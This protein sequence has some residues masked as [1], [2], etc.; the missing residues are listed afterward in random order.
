MKNK[1]ANKYIAA[2]MATAMLSV[3][4]VDAF[5]NDS[6][7]DKQKTFDINPVKALDSKSNGESSKA[8]TSNHVITLITG[9]VVT[10]TGVEGG[11]SVISVEY[12]DQVDGGAQFLTLGKD[13]Y[14]VPNQAMPYLASGLLDEELFNITALIADGYDDGEQS[15]LPVIVQYAPTKARFEAAL[16]AALA[17]S[18]RTN[19][20]ESIGGVAVSADKEQVTSFWDDIT[21][22]VAAA[23]SQKAGVQLNGVIEKIWLDGR[24]EANLAQSVPMI[25]APTAWDAG[26]DGAGVKIAVLDS[27]IDTEHPDVAGQID[28]AV[29]FVPGEDALDY[30][31]HGTHVA[32]T[33]LGT[34]AASEGRNKG[35][36]PGA[37]LLTGKVLASNGFGQDSWVIEGMEW[38]AENAKVVNMSLGDPTPSDGTDPMSQAVN[39]L[40]KETGALFVIAS[41]NAGTEGIGSPGAADAAL[42]VG[43]VDKSDNLAATSTRGPRYMESGLKPDLVAPGTDITAARSHLAKQGM[44]SY[45]TLSGTSM[46]APHVAGAAAILSQRYPEWTGEQLKN[47][48]MSSTKKL[49]HI[50][51]YEGGSGRLDVAAATSNTIFA[52]GSLDFGHYTWPHDGDDSVE[53]T[54]T[55]TN[56]SDSPVTLELSTTFKD[57]NGSEAPDGL[58][59]LSS[60]EVTVPA[61]GSADVFV[62]VDPESGVAGNRYQGQLSAIVDG[63]TVAHTAMVMGKEEEKYALTINATDR[64]GSPAQTLISIVG[65]NKEPEFLAVV[66]TKELRLPPGVYSVMSLMD[67]DMDTDHAGVALLGNPEIKLDGPQTL[68]LDARNA[69]EITANVPEKT[70]ASFRKMEFHRSFGEPNVVIGQYQLPPTMDKMYAEPAVA[71]TNGEL[72][73]NTRWR[74]I[75][76]LITIN[77]GETELDV[78]AQSGSTLLEGKHQLAAVYAGYGAAKDYVGLD[79]KDKVVVV[80]RS[81][82]I[83]GPARAAAAY[84]AGAKLVITVNDS[85]TELI[86]WVGKEDYTGD[87]PIAAVSVSGTE[88]EQLIKAVSSGEVMLNIEGTIDSPYVYDLVD[89]YQKHIP[90]DLSYSPSENELVKIDAQYKSDRPAPASEFRYDI[91]TYAEYGVGNQYKLSLPSVRTEWVSA[92]KGGTIWYHSARVLGEWEVRQPAVIYQP[93]Q[94]LNEDWFAPVVRPRFGDGFWVPER[95]EN[96]LQF[97]VPPLADSGDGHTGADMSRSGTQ[98][99][100]LY[101]GSELVEEAPGEMIFLNDAP[102][103]KTQYRLESDISRD[104][105]RWNTSVNTHTAWTIWSVKQKEFH[106]FLPMISLDYKVDT[107]MLGNAPAGDTIKLGLSASQI[108]YASGNGNIE[109]ASLEV[110]YNEGETWEKVNVV[111]EGKGWTAEIRNPKKSGTYVS[112]RASAW[113]DVG[114]RIDQD[115]IKAFGISDSAPAVVDSAIIR[116][117]VER[118][119]KEGE[120]KNAQAARALKTHLTAVAQ[121]EKQE[122][123]DKVMKHMKG[124]K[125]LLDQQKGSKLISDKAYNALVASAD[126][127]MKNLK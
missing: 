96:D 115:V 61:K 38:A 34:G 33:V 50:K 19:V 102:A 99:L 6:F 120:F 77:D 47:A 73:M 41:G 54:V 110:S 43:N 28:K 66:G 93:G 79:V 69:Q 124:F 119:E 100:K 127:M 15:T 31:G 108:D 113:D 114:N 94:R 35:V 81:A 42:T 74:L 106:T 107:D 29:S 57:N 101:Q 112:L 18:E 64:D 84:A 71:V 21:Q 13:T 72:D 30:H 1:N 118:F 70:E 46:A 85:P 14:V 105:A 8:S 126:E 12:A 52:G 76:P 45:I 91:P 39:S 20:L 88:G 44:G 78:L 36:A 7:L 90:E 56:E 65:P 104:P 109:G 123:G 9:D 37:N 26:L 117:L 58:V 121:Y 111:R 82:K 75:K 10:V 125:V 23:S 40:S 4:A 2:M 49:D 60:N 97:N 32:S 5:A 89:D 22:N 16:P 25:G 116:A 3:P 24:V 83:S 17:G 95:F 122:A 98:T 27:G 103:G 48:L 92:S 11:K 59:T 63:Q 55:Y 62:T 68:E 80:K 86:E 51:P 87:T 53:K 67:V